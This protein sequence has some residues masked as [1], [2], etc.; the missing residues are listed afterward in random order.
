MPLECPKCGRELLITQFVFLPKV[1]Y[2][3]TTAN[4]F[5][6]RTVDRK[7]AVSLF[8]ELCDKEFFEPLMVVIE[9]RNEDNYQLMVKGEYDVQQI[10]LFLKGRGFS[11]EVCKNYLVIFKG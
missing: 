2:I 10:E 9:Q 4:L 7:T 11:L 3:M 6:E 1:L 8:K 5:W